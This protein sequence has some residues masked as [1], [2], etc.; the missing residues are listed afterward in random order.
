MNGRRGVLLLNLGTPDSPSPRDVATYLREFL[1]DPYVVD[2]PWILRWILVNILILPRRKK[3]S[4]ELYQKIW[5]QQR[6]SP[7]RYHLDDLGELLGKKLEPGVAVSWA[8]RYGSPSIEAS[9]RHL[10]QAH[11]DL[12]ELLVIPLYPQYSLAASESSIQKTREIAKKLG[13]KPTLHFLPP[14]FHRKEF[15]SAFAQMARP[16]VNQGIYDHVIFTFHGLPERQIKRCD[17]GGVHCLA[18][19]QCCDTL[20]TQNQNCYRAQCY[21]TARALAQELALPA[22]KYSVAFQSRLGRTPW[23]RPYTD[24]LYESLP[25]KGIKK[26]LVISPSFVADCLETLE[27][28]S[29][30]GKDQF[31][32][33]GGQV[34]DLVPSLNAQPEWAQAL[35]DW[36]AEWTKGQSAPG[37]NQPTLE[38]V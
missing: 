23:I 32:A 15:I 8:M 30:R 33:A 10:S 21:A 16:A 38:S 28:V 35:S 31:T 34:L 2:I 19:E 26:I 6:G 25:K 17:L 27:E 12:Q 14:F 1:M 29:I 24:H 4:A 37:A 7:L 5:S 18:S 3:S 20:V 22:Q 36:V 9:L 13:F 11:P